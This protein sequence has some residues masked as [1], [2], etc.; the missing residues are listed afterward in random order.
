VVKDVLLR[1]E[2]LQA[3]DLK[4]RELEKAKDAIPGRIETLLVGVRAKEAE[5]AKIDARVAELDRER[6]HLEANAQDYAARLARLQAQQLEIKNQKEYEAL[7]REMDGHKKHRSHFEDEA[8][9]TMAMLEDLGKTRAELGAA[10]DASR[11]AVAEE[12]GALEA[13]L[14]DLNASIAQEEA[15]RR[16]L[17]EGL[18]ADVLRRY[19]QIRQRRGRAVVTIQSSGVCAGCNRSLPPQLFNIILRLSSIE[20]CPGCQRFL[21]FRPPESQAPAES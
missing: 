9:R 1:L 18:P 10:A 21:F 17:T 3:V 12:V 19:D 6:R 14:G 4:V 7:L 15:G 11:A 13:Q 20:Q 5:V 8:L 16:A 2:A